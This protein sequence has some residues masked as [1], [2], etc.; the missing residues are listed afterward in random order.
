[1]LPPAFERRVITFLRKISEF[2]PDEQL[3]PYLDFLNMD[4]TIDQRE[5]EKHFGA[6]KTKKAISS[7]VREKLITKSY[8]LEKERVKPRVV[9]YVNLKLTPEEAQQVLGKLIKRPSKQAEL[10]KYFI[11]NPRPTPLAEIKAKTGTAVHSLQALLD[12]GW[13]EKTEIRVERD[14]LANRAINLS[15][16]I[17]LTGAQDNAFQQIRSS[18]RQQSPDVF[19]SVWSDRQRQD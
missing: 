4:E 6:L 17:A 7:L 13:I 9:T 18:M 10:L 16:P 5:L 1:M 19:L 3:R 14:P 8:A 11:E 15:F 12:K 2:T